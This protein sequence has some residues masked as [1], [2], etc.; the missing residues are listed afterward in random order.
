MLEFKFLY[1]LCLFT[2]NIESAPAKKDGK[3]KR[4]L[5]QPQAETGRSGPSDMASAAAEETKQGDAETAKPQKSTRR[6]LVEVEVEK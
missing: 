6:N 5:E 1:P 4:R 2:S 3:K